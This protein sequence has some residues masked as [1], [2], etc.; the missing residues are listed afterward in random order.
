[1]L[2]CI[3]SSCV[4]FSA[5]LAE[6]QRLGGD[7]PRC[8]C[9]RGGTPIRRT[10]FFFGDKQSEFLSGEQPKCDFSPSWKLFGAADHVE[11]NPTGSHQRCCLLMSTSPPVFAP[12]LRAGRAA[13]AAH[14]Y[15]FQ[16][17]L[18]L[19]LRISHYTFNTWQ[20]CSDLLL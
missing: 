1:M 2:V 4:L 8:V 13:L 7:L 5:S 11:A 18:Y 3:G 15:T 9:C 17:T 6:P 19:G 14:E 10:C 20:P 12:L 16:I